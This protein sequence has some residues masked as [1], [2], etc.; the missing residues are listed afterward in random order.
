MNAMDVYK[1]LLKSHEIWVTQTY[2]TSR[3][4]LSSP[5]TIQVCH[6]C[7]SIEVS[8]YLSIESGY[9]ARAY[10]I[11][12]TSYESE[13]LVV[14]PTILSNLV[15]LRSRWDTDEYHSK[16]LDII[17]LSNANLN[18]RYQYVSLTKKNISTC[19]VHMKDRRT[20][21]QSTSIFFTTTC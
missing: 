2:A 20:G 5:S 1:R 9:R 4:S 6:G 10:P 12:E 11:H 13:K 17:I 16:W 8:F 15:R 19:H 3:L 7:S 18:K 21:H 14:R